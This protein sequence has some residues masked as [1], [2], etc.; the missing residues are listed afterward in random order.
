MSNDRFIGNDRTSVVAHLVRR[1]T[2][3]LCSTPYAPATVDFTPKAWA[4]HSPRRSQPRA[5]MRYGRC[6]E[7]LRYDWLAPIG[8]PLDAFGG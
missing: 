1:E 5:V 8:R 3:R 2:G 7:L 6:A 4:A